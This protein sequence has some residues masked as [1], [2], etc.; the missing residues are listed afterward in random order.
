MDHFKA[1]LSPCPRW[2]QRVRFPAPFLAAFRP[3]FLQIVCW[4]TGIPSGHSCALL[5]Q[6]HP[7]QQ[8][9]VAAVGA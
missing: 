2:L 5:R 6:P 8:V 1:F 3:L 7:A 9:G 4:P